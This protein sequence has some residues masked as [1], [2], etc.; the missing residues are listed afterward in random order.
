MIWDREFDG[1]G[2]KPRLASER[3]YRAL[4]WIVF[5]G[6]LLLELRAVY[7]LAIWLQSPAVL[8][9]VGGLSMANWMLAQYLVGVWLS[10]QGLTRPPDPRSRQTRTPLLPDGEPDAAI[11]EV[12]PPAS[13]WLFCAAICGGIT[14]ILAGILTISRQSGTGDWFTSWEWLGV[15][16]TVG[17]GLLTV[18]YS[19]VVPHLNAHTTVD[20]TGIWGYPRDLAIRRRFIPWSAIATCE[21]E[22]DHILKGKPISVRPILLDAAGHRLIRLDLG[23]VSLADRDRLIRAIQVRLPGSIEI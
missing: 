10:R 20:A 15:L 1:V 6:L 11:V 3:L 7:P 17:M 14:L 8:G 2:P 18:F 5:G 13:L 21:L 9:F 12:A 23:G 16:A 4:D 19:V 22:T